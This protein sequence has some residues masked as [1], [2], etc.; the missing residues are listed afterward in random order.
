MKDDGAEL[1]ER[2]AGAAIRKILLSGEGLGTKQNLQATLNPDFINL[3]MRFKMDPKGKMAY[4]STDN[5]NIT[6]KWSKPD[7][8]GHGNGYSVQEP[9]ECFQG[10]PKSTI[11]QH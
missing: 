5:A 6:R 8:H 11:G 4:D 7:K 9:G 2:R 1:D 10:Q 3:E